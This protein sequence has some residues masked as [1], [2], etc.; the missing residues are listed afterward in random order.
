MAVDG[1]SPSLIIPCNREKGT[2]G[3]QYIPTASLGLVV[4]AENRL[5][6]KYLDWIRFWVVVVVGDPTHT[7]GLAVDLPAVG[8][9][10]YSHR[11]HPV[12][13]V[14]VRIDRNECYRRRT[15][16]ISQLN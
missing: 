6:Y 5:Q 3:D 10:L 8:P 13:A 14:W 2:D 16:G 12:S 11:P 1:S 9:I 4:L 15:F 7:V